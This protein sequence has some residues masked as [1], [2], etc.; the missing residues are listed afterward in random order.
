MSSACN[1]INNVNDVN[2]VFFQRAGKIHQ[3]RNLSCEDV[4]LARKRENI[5]FWGLADG[6]SRRPLC[7]E[8][9]RRSLQV[10]AD[11]IEKRGIE[12]LYVQPFLDELQFE[13]IR[14]IRNELSTLAYHHQ[15]LPEDFASTLLGFA[16]NPETGHSVSIHLGDGFLIGVKKDDSILMLSP[17]E[18]GISPSHTWLTT[19]KDVLAHIRFTFGTIHE[20]KRILLATDGA[21]GL[22][23]GRNISLHAHYLLTQGTQAD[24]SNYLASSP[25]P[26]DV[27]CIILDWITQEIA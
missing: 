23:I 8:G 17:P 7:I 20:Y 13:L 18:N 6:Q 11:F 3:R 22:C 4:M 25:A 12:T 14:E 9:A 21:D 24:I 10:M 15:A 19:S 5:C 16:Y 2:C 27:S 1:A 26:D